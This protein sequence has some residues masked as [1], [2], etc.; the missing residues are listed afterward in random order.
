MT[1]G[2]QPE[3][4]G[5]AS[6][7]SLST[8][9]WSKLAGLLWT[10]WTDPG[11]DNSLLAW[12]QEEDLLSANS[13]CGYSCESISPLQFSFPSNKGNSLCI[14]SVWEKSWD[15][16]R[17]R[18]ALSLLK[19]WLLAENICKNIGE[20]LYACISVCVSICLLHTHLP[21]IPSI[22]KSLC[23]LF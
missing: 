20:F 15:R 22:L 16:A 1:Y 9:A 11:S 19:A 5:S 12:A 2:G 8:T 7:R 6:H 3:W 23:S 10:T 13:C 14:Y 4:I 21:E 18:W 17:A